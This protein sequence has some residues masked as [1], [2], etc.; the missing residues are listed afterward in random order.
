MHHRRGLVRGWSYARGFIEGLSV[1]TATFVDEAEV[2]MEI[3]PIR[4]LR[5]WD[6]SPRLLL[7]LVAMSAFEQIVHLDLRHNRLGDQCLATFLTQPAAASLKSLDLT[8]NSLAD[9]SARALL[10]APLN[11]L[12]RLVISQNNFSQDGIF[13]L[14]ERFGEAVQHENGDAADD[15]ISR[16]PAEPVEQESADAL[17]DG[18]YVTYEGDVLYEDGHV[19]REFNPTAADLYHGT[20]DHETDEYDDGDNDQR[21]DGD[22]PWRGESPPPES[23][24]EW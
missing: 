8:G 1:D 17:E 12:S 21:A 10:A 11:T 14:C 18:R 13:G 6:A 19:N 16:E 7:E 3:G 2:L 24:D 22:D 23:N 15:R 9:A 5:L 4:T 20:E